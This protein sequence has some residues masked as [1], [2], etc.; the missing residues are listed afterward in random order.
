MI[1]FFVTIFKTTIF[2]YFLNYFLKKKYPEKYNEYLI[3][4]SLNA[5]YITS[6]IQI[7]LKKCKKYVCESNPRLAT[8]INNYIKTNNEGKNNVEFILKGKVIYSST[9]ENV[10]NYIIDTPKEDFILYSDYS[11]VNSENM[12]INKKI[13]KDLIIEDKNFDYELSDIRF[14]LCE[15]IVN[16]SVYKID[17]KTDNYNYYLV[18]NIIN[19]HFI[20]YYLLNH[21]NESLSLEDID[22]KDSKLILKIIDNNVNICEID[23][24]NDTNFI[25][26]KK[27]NYITN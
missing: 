23:I 11:T 27:D 20:F 8:L 6:V 18:D 3:A 5:I 10:I 14:M 7:K 17:L 2:S 26:I 15:L 4:I 9:K 12:C 19:K 1:T 24:T 13:M 25:Q 16:D 22:N 21:C